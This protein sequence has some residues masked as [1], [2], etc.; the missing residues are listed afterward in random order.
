MQRE[1]IK[2]PIFADQFA[3]IDF[4]AEPLPILCLYPIPEP[5]ALESLSL[6]IFRIDLESRQVPWSELADLPRVRIKQPLICQIFNWSERVEWEG[7]RLVDVLDHLS[8]ETTHKGYYAF[9]SRDG[10]YFE[11]LSRTEARD[12]RVLLV[13]GLNGKPLP[14]E[15]GSP[16]RLVVPF[17]QGYKSV[18]W[19]KGIRAVETDPIGIK[20]LRCQSPTAELSDEWREKYGMMPPEE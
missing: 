5:V 7:V 14:L 12:P 2:P 16:L 20:Q 3:R 10:H 8:L 11:S 9:Y 6:S 1:G 17:L 18:K 15:Y 4:E 19:I 13:Y